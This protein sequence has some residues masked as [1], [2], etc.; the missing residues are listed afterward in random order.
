MSSLLPPSVAGGV[1]LIFSYNGFE[2]VDGNGYYLVASYAAAAVLGDDKVVFDADPSKVVIVGE[3][4]V[5]DKLTTLSFL[6]PLLD[7]GRDE[8]YTG[9]GAHY[10]AGT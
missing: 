9:L 8:A 2:L 10:H 5:V 6:L 1:F 3:T 7:E 4:V